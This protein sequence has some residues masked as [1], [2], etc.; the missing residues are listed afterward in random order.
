MVMGT[1]PMNCR[2]GRVGLSLNKGISIE[3]LPTPLGLTNKRVKGL[4]CPSLLAPSVGGV[5]MVSP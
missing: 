2:M 4:P 1:F 3:I 5:I